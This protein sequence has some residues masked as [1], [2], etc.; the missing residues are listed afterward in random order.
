MAPVIPHSNKL[1]KTVSDVSSVVEPVFRERKSAFIRLFTNIQEASAEGVRTVNRLLLAAAIALATFWFSAVTPATAGAPVSFRATKV[2]GHPVSMVTTDLSDRRVELCPVLANGKTGQT[3][4]LAAMAKS[5]S[6]VAAVNGTFFNAYSDMTSWGT[7]LIDGTPHRIGNSGGAIG[8]TADGRLKV[9]RLRVQIEG[10][11]DGRDDWEHWWYA[12]DVNRN[13]EDPQAI[14]IFT[15]AFG[16]AMRAPVAA[17]VSVRNGRVASIQSGPVPIPPDGCVIGFGPDAQHIASR[18][19]VGDAVGVRYAFSDEK[20]DPLDW[21]DVRHVI[22][23]GPLLVKDGQ[24]VL[25][26]AADKMNEPKFLTKA[27]WSFVG[28]GWNGKAVIGTVSGVTMK[29][30]AQTVQKLGLK[31]AVGLDGNASCGLYFQGGYKIRPGRKLSNCLAVIVHPEK[32]VPVRV[33]GKLLPVPGYL[34]PPGVTMVPVRGVFE[35]LGATV[36]WN[37]ENREATVSLNGREVVLRCSGREAV[38]DG[39]VIT[40]PAAPE[41]RSGRTFV[42]LRFVVE[43]LGLK[44][45]WDQNTYTVC[46]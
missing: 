10:S 40:L 42:P 36:S 41:V 37:Q 1:G 18:F 21:D 13:V 26:I 45:E 6:A 22:Q 38:V 28:V 24:N 2:D 3:T 16:Q 23:A 33:G 27:S 35:Y 30:M 20:G 11:I 46:F 4:D 43:S 31:D 14:I 15:P 7:I 25:D 39:K 32:Q 19:N 8:I 9:A 29:E 34:R 5:V 17:T 44:P 12:W